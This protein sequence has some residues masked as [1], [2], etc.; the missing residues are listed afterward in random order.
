[1]YA[2]VEDFASVGH[3]A[4]AVPPPRQL[5]THRRVLPHLHAEHGGGAHVH[6]HLALLELPVLDAALLAHLLIS[7]ERR[8]IGQQLAGGGRVFDL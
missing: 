1:V 3:E 2:A 7:K 5:F 8:V 4:A 6:V